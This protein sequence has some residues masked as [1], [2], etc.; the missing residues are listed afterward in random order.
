M[1]TAAVTGNV[2]AL[3]NPLGAPWRYC[4]ACIWNTATSIR[5]PDEKGIVPALIDRVL[6]IHQVV[7]VD[8]ICRAALLRRSEFAKVLEALVAGKPLELTGADIKFG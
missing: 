1:A 7:P 6:P 4:G 5:I 8:T 2:T 3:R